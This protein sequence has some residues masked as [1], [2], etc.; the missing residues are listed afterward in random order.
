MSWARLISA[1]SILPSAA[2]GWSGR[3]TRTS[4]SRVE[5]SAAHAGVA[6]LSDNSEIDLTPNHEIHDLLRMPG[7]HKQANGRVSLRETDQDLGQ[8]VGADC[9][10]NRERELADDAM[11]DRPDERAAA[12]DR[13]D[14]PVGMGRKARPAGVRTMPECDRRKSAVAS[15]SSSAW[16]RAL[17]AG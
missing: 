12:L 13:L 10:S 15:S 6:E 3:A 11:F 5:R 17:S 2:S 16:S 8:D 1:T 9:G 14:R 4:S 7:P